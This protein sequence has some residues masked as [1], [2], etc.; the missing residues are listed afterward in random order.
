M[1]VRVQMGK[2]P[3]GDYGLRVVGPDSTTI[4]DGTSDMFRIIAD[5]SLASATGPNNGSVT[6]EVTLATGLTYAPMHTGSSGFAYGLLPYV[7]LQIGAL[8]K[9]AD[10]IV[11]HTEVSGGTSTRVI[12]KY[13]SP[14]N[15]SAQAWS[16]KFYIYE[17]A[18]L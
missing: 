9:V 1:P 17:Q 12:A 5:G 13:I 2:L 18:S 15:R 8:E 4:I 6:Q 11:Q 14:L 7:G 10:L 3:N 16:V